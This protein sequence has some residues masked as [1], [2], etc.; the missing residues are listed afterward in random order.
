[1]LVKTLAIELAHTRPGALCIALHPGTVDTA[2]SRPFQRG[3]A[4]GK[5]FTPATAAE[6][7]LSVIDRVEPADSGGCFAWDG[8][9]IAP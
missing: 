1:M 3:V 5:L 8:A 2:L 4:Q 7:M 9:P 6:R